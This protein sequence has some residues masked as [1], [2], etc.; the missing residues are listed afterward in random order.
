V[1]EN[2]ITANRIAPGIVA[3]GWLT[4]T[5]IPGSSQDITI[6][7]EFVT[8]KAAQN[9]EDCAEVVEFLSTNLSGC[10]AE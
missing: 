1:A 8:L 7:P 4:A 9:H 6:G 2:R 3:T 10:V 5:L